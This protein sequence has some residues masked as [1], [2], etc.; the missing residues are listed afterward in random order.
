MR[1]RI[2]AP[3]IASAL[4]LLLAAGAAF[5]HTVAEGDQAYVQTAPGASIAPFVYLGAK[6]MVTGYDHLLF[7]AGVIFF[8]YRMREVALYVTLFALGHSTTLLLG[9]FAGLE[10][11]PFLIDAIIGLSVAYKALDNLDAFRSWF[12]V[13]PDP[14]AAVLV[15]GFFHGLG[16]AARLQELDLPREGLATNMISFN[17]GV[18][19]GQL[20]ALCAMLI[21]MNYWRRTASFLRHAYAANVALLAA[22]FLLM[23]H[24]LAAYALN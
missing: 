13:Q 8:L 9:V 18:E 24:Q 1:H 3:C 12:G 11:N 22:G 23:G 10:A 15:F 20:L 14:R 7:L 16:L 5:A 6:H 4:V 21:V 19:I 2:S 17:A